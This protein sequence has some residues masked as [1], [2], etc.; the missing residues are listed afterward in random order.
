MYGVYVSWNTY[1]LLSTSLQEVLESEDRIAVVHHNN[2]RS[3]C[4]VA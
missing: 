2:S 1:A 4:S 3:I